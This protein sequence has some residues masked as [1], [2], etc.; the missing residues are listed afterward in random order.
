M[1]ESISSIFVSILDEAWLVSLELSLHYENCSVFFFQYLHGEHEYT[2]IVI[3]AT[4]Q[5]KALLQA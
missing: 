2:Y 1:V 5:V 3:K 4:M